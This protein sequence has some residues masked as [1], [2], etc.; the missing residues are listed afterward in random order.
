VEKIYFMAVLAATTLACWSCQNF[1]EPE[2]VI[3]SDDDP[4]FNGPL[5]RYWAF[6]NTATDSIL[7][8]RGV[9]T[10]V[11]YA[12]GV[13]GQAY[14]GS[15][16]SQIEYA[17]A[18][19]LAS[20]ESFSVSFWFNTAKHTGGAQCLFMLP[21]TEDFWGNLFFMIEGNDSP[22]DSTMIAKFNFAGQWVEFTQ[23]DNAN[24]L[25][26]WPNAYNQWKHV[27]FTYDAAT[28]KL[29][30]YLDGRKLPLAESVSDRKKD[31]QPLGALGLKN[32][33][34]FVI[35]G[36]QQHIGIRAPADAWMLHYTGLLDQLRIYTVAITE[37]DVATLYNEKK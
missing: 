21:N 32:V 23:K 1:E 6:E 25:N 28:S 13:R 15:T 10:N 14:K 29:S 37:T 2:M 16:T 27:V 36:Y 3:I 30:A 5:Q 12:A 8:S 11:S 9:S 35:G 22:T 7:G 34:K 20:M 26:R 24:G 17:S 4:A 33:S 31:G 19:K 18:G